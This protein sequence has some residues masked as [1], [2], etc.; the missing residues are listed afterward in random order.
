MRRLFMVERAT[1]SHVN[2]MVSCVE[3]IK[4]RF[5]VITLTPFVLEL[6]VSTAY[7]LEPVTLRLVIKGGSNAANFILSSLI[8]Q[9]SAFEFP[10][11]EA[12]VTLSPRQ[13]NC[14]SQVIEVSLSVLNKSN[15]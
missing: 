13:A 9:T 7:V 6:L 3:A 11:A 14:L 15:I 5:V 2:R 1:F 4:V 10:V 8:I 12:H